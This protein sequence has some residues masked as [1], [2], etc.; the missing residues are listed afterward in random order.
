MINYDDIR[1]QYKVYTI[2][3]VEMIHI[4]D[5]AKIAHRSIQATRHLIEDGNKIRH[6]KAFR[7]R[8]RLMIPVLELLGFPFL[9]AGT[10]EYERAI[11]HYRRDPVDGIYKKTLCKECSYGNKCEERRT[12]EETIVPPG[13]D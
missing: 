5:F 12:I 11:L 4:A 6:M 10:S 9:Q 8:S 7:D 1:E 2:H 13:D 3:G